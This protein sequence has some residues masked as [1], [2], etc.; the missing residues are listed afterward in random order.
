MLKLNGHPEYFNWNLLLLIK[1][2][3][4]LRNS[5]LYFNIK[6]AKSRVGYC[7]VCNSGTT[8]FSVPKGCTELISLIL[9]K[10]HQW[11]TRR[12]RQ[13]D[14]RYEKCSNNRDRAGRSENKKKKNRKNRKK[15]R[16]EKIIRFFFHLALVDINTSRITLFLCVDLLFPA[17]QQNNHF[18]CTQ[19]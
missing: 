13:S 17:Q 8:H 4:V 14:L 9:Y 11:R 10:Q 5:S 3:N 2:S 6:N 18:C 15:E 12:G 1:P 16:K 7:Q 19:P